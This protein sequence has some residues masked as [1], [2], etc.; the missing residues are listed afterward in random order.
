M[1]ST[2]SDVL[3]AH[4][5]SA[6]ADPLFG[7]QRL[8]VDLLVLGLGHGQLNGLAELSVLVLRIRRFLH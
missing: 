1:V 3:E 4:R 8:E 6:L 2:V 7:V 5:Y